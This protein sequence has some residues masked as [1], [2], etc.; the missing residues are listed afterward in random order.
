M[1]LLRTLKGCET[2]MQTLSCIAQ[3][4]RVQLMFKYR[5]DKHRDAFAMVAERDGDC[6]S[7]S[8]LYQTLGKA[9]GLTELKTVHID[10][11]F[12]FQLSHTDEIPGG[13]A[14]QR[15]SFARH[16]ILAVRDERGNQ[17]HFDPVFG[18][19]VDPAHYG[20]LARY[21]RLAR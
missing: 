11:P 4:N 16:T 9:V 5:M 10:R 13:Q 1:R 19:E 18:C 7:F 2:P 21:R 3:Q 14:N 20:D 15:F 6:V 17:R 8:N 12:A